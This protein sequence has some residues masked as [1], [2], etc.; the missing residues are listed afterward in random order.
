MFGYLLRFDISIDLS[1]KLV[2]NQVQD[3]G[4]PEPLFGIR[5]LNSVWVI[6]AKEQVCQFSDVSPGELQS[7]VLLKPYDIAVGICI[8][9]FFSATPF[10]DTCQR[11]FHLVVF[12]IL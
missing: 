6:G 8:P 4:P 7:L 2:F 10:T 11:K 12:A 9:D 3:T 5:L 1:F